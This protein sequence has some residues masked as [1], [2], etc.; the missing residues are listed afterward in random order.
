[1]VPG[2]ENHMGQLK[3]S[4]EE[5]IWGDNTVFLVHSVCN[6]HRLF[7]NIFIFIFFFKMFVLVLFASTFII[8]VE[9]FYLQFSTWAIKAYVSAKRKFAIL[10]TEKEK[11]QLLCFTK[12][13]T[14]KWKFISPGECLS[15]THVGHDIKSP[16]FFFFPHW[17]P[18]L[19][20]VV[21][22]TAV[23]IFS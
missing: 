5:G 20:G 19:C 2:L 12:L 17:Q 6:A 9:W 11:G 15:K 7:F 8:L 3:G 13:L 16:K 22:D 23:K 1:M 18:T 21:K 4:G 14:W 10:Q